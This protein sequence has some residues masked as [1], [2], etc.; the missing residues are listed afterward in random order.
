MLRWFEHSQV[1]HPKRDWVANPADLGRPFEDVF[2]T[3]SDGVRLSA[4]FYPADAQSPRARF[5][6]LVCHGNG[7][8]ISHR[9]DLCSSLLRTGANVLLLD[10]RGYGRSEGKLT[11]EGTYLDAQGAYEWLRQRGFSAENIIAFGESLGGGIACE[12]AVREPLGGLILQSTFTNIADIGAEIFPWLPVRWLNT[13][14]YDTWKKLP[15]IHVPVLVTHSRDDTLIHFR[16]AE[17][18]YAAANEPKMFWE[19]SGG[20]NYSEISDYNRCL[21][22]IERFFRLIEKNAGKMRA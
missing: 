5:A 8:N 13:I 22:G 16:H 19:T 7:G 20:H 14:K 15:R 4:W 6:I 2:I 11:E 3:A 17:K 21:E 9:L 10:Y 12:L 1:F 18:N